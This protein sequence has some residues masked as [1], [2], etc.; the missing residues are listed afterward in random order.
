MKGTQP[1]QKSNMF[2]HLEDEG[3]EDDAP[4]RP[5][6][7]TSMER[8]AMANMQ[9]SETAFRR[10]RSNDVGGQ[11]G[12]AASMWRAAGMG[13]PRDSATDEMDAHVDRL[14]AP[15]EH[16]TLKEYWNV[17]NILLA[18]MHE[19]SIGPEE[20]QQRAFGIGQPTSTW[21]NRATTMGESDGTEEKGQ[22]EHVHI[23]YG[24][25]H[26]KW[27]FFIVIG[28]YRDHGVLLPLFT[29]GGK[30]LPGYR[31]QAEYVSIFDRRI[32]NERR[33]RGNAE[34]MQKQSEH[35]PVY[36]QC[37][38]M[39]AGLHEL[40]VARL[41]YPTSRSV[42]SPAKLMGFL[43]RASLAPLLQ[44]FHRYAP[45]YPMKWNFLSERDCECV[46]SI[47]KAVQDEDTT[48]GLME[49]YGPREID[50]AR[51]RQQETRSYG[52]HASPIVPGVGRGGSTRPQNDNPFMNYDRA[53][54]SSAPA[55]TQSA[56]S[57]PQAE[58]SQSQNE[59]GGPSDKWTRTEPRMEPDAEEFDGDSEEEQ[60]WDT[61]NDLA[62]TRGSVFVSIFNRLMGK[63]EK[64]APSTSQKSKIGIPSTIATSTKTDLFRKNAGNKSPGPAAGPSSATGPISEADKESEDEPE[65]FRPELHEI[66]YDLE[67]P[68]D[69]TDARPQLDSVHWDLNHGVKSWWSTISGQGPVEVPLT[70]FER[71]ELQN[72]ETQNAAWS[73][74][75]RKKTTKLELVKPGVYRGGSYRAGGDN[76]A[77]YLPE[78]K[79]AGAKTRLSVRG[80]NR[81]SEGRLPAS[82]ASKQTN[83]TSRGQAS[84]GILGSDTGDQARPVVDQALLSEG[85]QNWASIEKSANSIVAATTMTP[86][87]LQRISQTALAFVEN[88]AQGAEFLAQHA[89][90]L[91]PG[92]EQLF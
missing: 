45:S 9:A 82:S 67:G 40:S 26:S 19:P 20:R 90:V 60:D 61:I 48:E 5:A 86:E 14:P 65:D 18:P 51:G 72:F 11:T 8:Q 17:G 24:W 63:S 64:P 57:A 13:P 21:R 70:D 3:A 28:R 85:Q 41:T 49:R 39:S 81:H 56:S 6:P 12:R 37:Y 42:D 59:E 25:I 74:L 54:A 79:P 22:D 89:D 55:S 32:V 27:R 7:D 71:R 31:N 66:S 88:L 92:L 29:F 34:P 58:A 15:P 78:A 53:T 30:G 4:S 76:L 75:K 84:D 68:L 36:A 43:E 69:P 35:E 91:R 23:K 52:P 80:L 83:S 46:R 1:G 38:G 44:L 33:A 47:A 77:D 50:R 73:F 2:M 10:L 62:E 87:D 16:R